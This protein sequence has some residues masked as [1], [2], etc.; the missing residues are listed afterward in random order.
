[1]IVH[2]VIY[3]FL[4]AEYNSPKDKWKHNHINLIINK[5]NSSLTEQVMNNPDFSSGE[6]NQV[7]YRALLSIRRDS[8]FNLPPDTIWHEKTFAIIDLD[9]IKL[10]CPKTKEELLA[11]QDEKILNLNGIILFE[12]DNGYYVIEGNHRMSEY[13]AKTEKSVIYGNVYIG[14]SLTNMNCPLIN[15][16]NFYAEENTINHWAQLYENEINPD[17]DRI[18]TITKI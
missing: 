2:K 8:W 18:V 3:A 17:A 10:L 5:T 1:M 11:Y 13:L 6:E 9:K 15:N 16:K 14:S 4:F 12:Q 7:R